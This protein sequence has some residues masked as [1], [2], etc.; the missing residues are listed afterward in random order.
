LVND[1]VTSCFRYPELSAVGGS[2]G[3]KATRPGI[4]RTKATGSSEET[5][6]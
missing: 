6:R 1:H 3:H 5:A 2:P 4:A